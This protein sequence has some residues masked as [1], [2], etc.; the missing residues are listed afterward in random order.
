MG[1]KITSLVVLLAAMLL[2]LPTQ[3]QMQKA[4]RASDGKAATEM[5]TLQKALKVDRAAIEQQQKALITK[6]MES[7]DPA[8]MELVSNWNWGAHAPQ[9]FVSSNV[10]VNPAM[11][12][13]AALAKLNAAGKKNLKVGAQK[14]TPNANISKLAG[15]KLTGMRKADANDASIEG[16]W[17][18]NLGDYYFQTSVGPITYDFEA[19]LDGTE[20]W[21]EDPTNNELPF[22][23][24]YNE[25]AGTLTFN[26]EYLGPT[27][28]YHIYQEPFVYNYTTDDL[29]VQT[30]VATYNASAGTISFK[31]DNGISWLAYTNSAGTG[32][33]AGYFGIYDL[34]GATKAVPAEPIDEEQA[35]QWTT[36]GM[37]TFIDA[38][39]LPSYSMGGVQI[40]PNEYTY[41]VEL[42]QNKANDKLYRLWKPYKSAG[43]LV[44][45]Q[46]LNQSTYQGQ[47]QI[48][49]TD[50]ENVIVV[51]CGLPAG[52]KNSQGE[53]YM[54]NLLGWYMNYLG[55]TKEQ[56]ISALGNDYVADT[57]VN[58]VV[59]INKTLFD[60]NSTHSDGYSWNNNPYQ[61]KII[62][63]DA[64]LPEPETIKAPYTSNL[65]TQAE[66]NK[67][68][69]V[70]N[71]NDGKTWGWSASNYA[72]YTYSLSNNADDY[73]ILPI[74]LEA[75]KNYNVTV[76][77][78]TYSER[79]PEKFEVVVGKAA[80]P[81]GLNVTAIANTT[82]AHSEFVDYEGDFTT[83]G[84]A[85]QWYVAIHCVSDADDWYLKVKS[86]TIEQGAEGTAP[87]A[88]AD[89]T[90]VAGEQGA[91]E[92]N[93]S[94]T[95]P[96]TSI[97]G[98]TLSG[99]QD[100]V[101][102]RD[103]VAVNTFKGVAAGA[104]LTW[105]D[106]DV[107]DG[108]S[109]TYYAQASNA[110][111]LGAKSEKVSVWVGQ[112]MPDD[113]ENVLVTGMPT[114]NSVSL[115]WDAV[116]G[117]NGGYI[118]AANAQYSVTTIEIEDFEILPGWTYPMPV[119]GETLGTVT[120]DT[121]LTVDFAGL[122]EGEKPGIQYFGVKAKVGANET[123]PTS[124]LAYVYTGAPYELPIVESFEGKSTHYLWDYNEITALGVSEDA[125]DEDG[126][127]LALIADGADGTVMFE[128]F[129]LNTK[130]AAN[131]T[132]LF[133]AKKG[134]SATDQL[135]V[136]GLAPD[137][138]KTTLKTVTLTDEYQTVKVAIPAD[139]AK[140]RWS[141]IGF[142]AELENGKNIL[143]DNIKVLDLYEYDLSVAVKAPAS[144]QAGNTAAITAT[145]KNEGENEATGYTVTVKAGEEVLVEETV[146][147]ALAPF[148]TKEFTAELATTIFDDA[149]DVTITATVEYTNDLNE[150]NNTAETIISVKE[151]AAAP[152][153]DVTAT[154]ED[155]SILV[156]W[157]APES[158]TEEVTEDVEAYEEFDTGDLTEDNLDE[159][160]GNIGE[161]TVYDGNREFGYGFNGITVPHLGEPNAWLVMN[162]ASSQVS[163]DLSA[164]HPAHSGSQYFISTCVAESEP[165]ADTD[166]WLISPELPGVAQTISFYACV[167]TDQYGKETFEVLAS[168]TDTN[169]ESFTLVKK[170]ETEATDWTEFTADLPAGT[171]YFAIR[172]TSNDI[173]GLK[174]DD[175]TYTVG[176]GEIDHFNIYL[177]GE[178]AATAAADAVTATLEDVADGEHTVAVSVVYT[179]GAESKPVEVTVSVATGID[180]ITV[181]TQPVDVYSLDGKLVRKQ[182]TTVSGLKGVYIVNGKK[183]ILK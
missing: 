128:S 115:A 61:A 94:L 58:G 30:I 121:K 165:I 103:D 88:P 152:V 69:V 151:S 127:A 12:R 60:F 85:G 10:Q 160:Y 65:T 172:H 120:G 21:F 174:I 107:K 131:P 26:R 81:E 123:D 40:D 100:V 56:A 178:L 38:W 158:S 33:A 78:A 13:T 43:A 166:H 132:L 17:T 146:N 183:V 126:V 112:D 25:A 90:A 159:H 104:A 182:T 101:I 95:A 8:M 148:A 11:V 116:K 141:K 86:V 119:E 55:V 67:W 145:V 144:V 20:L 139:L 92:V 47:I 163:Q 106:T 42:Q 109:Y 46:G 155:N 164:N 181:I 7:G 161:W 31:A 45:E 2:S 167:I 70:D 44:Y 66:F 72:Y 19:T 24:E 102:Y 98:S 15:K 138:T 110:S 173:F 111:G 105:Q 134:T 96:A 97:D 27:S 54:S 41:E 68:T 50:P 125:S 14:L 149:A 130:A 143:L 59:T 140:E 73:L 168:K 108:V 39:I 52:F 179:S 16:T 114:A 76:N 117:I 53:F 74:E 48:D 49:V 175:I 99:T 170:E 113:I 6:A 83:D 37:A 137:G 71:N 142:N 118:D 171:K 89:F 154:A 77:A 91:L 180:S 9:Q 5:R 157:T 136:Y 80:T 162:P 32:T 177:D 133:D 124:W 129:K 51:P 135:I 84:D 93:I 82:I 36:V 34:E 64:E 147:E 156:G 87:A 3:A 176:G 79:Y 63:P 150:D 153:T 4:K 57:Y 22:F 18:F 122:D 169:V 35:G 29:D 28:S 23:A 1:K 62:F 75:N